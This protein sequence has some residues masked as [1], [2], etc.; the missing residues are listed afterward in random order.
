VEE[1]RDPAVSSKGSSS[2]DETEIQK[3]GHLSALQASREYQFGMI[4]RFGARSRHPG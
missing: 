3:S 1:L 4:E 2:K